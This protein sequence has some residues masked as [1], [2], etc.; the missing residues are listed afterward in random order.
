M[1][2]LKIYKE[3]N[4]NSDWFTDHSSLAK[5]A[6][7]RLF[8]YTNTNFRTQD[9]FIAD[10]LKFLEI[11]NKPREIWPKQD[12]HGQEIHKHYVTNMIQSKL[13]K[14]DENE[15]FSR[16]SKGLLYADF[17]NLKIPE[18][19]RWFINYLFLLNGYYL[20]HKN[21][22]IFR[23]KE[24]L[25]GHFLSTEGITKDLLIKEAKILLQQTSFSSILRSQFFYFHSFY[26]DSDFLTCYLR[27]T[28]KEKEEL[29]FYIEKN[30][31]KENFQCCISKKYQP[32]GNFN[33]IMLLDETKVFLLTL[34][35]LESKK[36]EL[37]AYKIFFESYNKNISSLNG[38]V[39]NY[40][41]K[42][43]SI[44]DPIFE[45][46]FES[47]EVEI[48]DSITTFE[49]TQ[50]SQLDDRDI[51]EEYID[52]TSEVGR[53]KIK[54]IYSLRKRQAR[55]LSRYKCALEI[56]NNCKPIYFTA[57]NNGKNYLEL[58][59]FIPR[60]FRNDFSHSIEVL[61]NYITLCPRCHRQIHLALDRERKHLINSLYDDRSARL[62]VVGLK[63]DFKKAY[64][65]YK[66]DV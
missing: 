44:F 29:A 16:T 12:N 32:K 47:E 10:F 6:S 60:E 63:L 3:K 43:K 57:K 53:Q 11:E 26:N 38:D 40:L 48:A 42:N 54:A 15:L 64:E 33:K 58:H 50:I 51:A 41:Y 19:D 52:E 31:N 34:L 4:K 62:E 45:D 61:A 65:Y 17:I 20:N 21:Y 28:D 27:S 25:L 66:I 46:V 13:F 59:H 2:L 30:L 22:I 55:M 37:D 49:T 35:F 18:S 14:K 5:G 39:L 1:S 56:I 8:E 23:V 7:G 36:V 24:D 9:T